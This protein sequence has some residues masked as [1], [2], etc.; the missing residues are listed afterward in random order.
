MLTSPRS[1][2]T[3]AR[4]RGFTLVELLVVIAIIGTLV[5]L[6]LPAVQSAREAARR[7][8]CTNNMRQIGLSF[9]NYATAFNKLPNSRP[10]AKTTPASVMSWPV[11]VLDYFE[12]GSLARLYDKTVPWNAGNNAVAG[13]TVIPLFVCPSAPGSARLA[14]T[15]RSTGR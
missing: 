14:P 8:S 7:T 11:L 12:E 4:P 13:T 9:Q 6:L 2:A 15:R 5:G 3:V 1:A 10:V